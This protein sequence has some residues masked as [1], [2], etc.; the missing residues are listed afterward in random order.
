MDHFLPVEAP[1]RTALR[2]RSRTAWFLFSAS[3]AT[4]FGVAVALLVFWPLS[5]WRRFAGNICVGHTQVGLVLELGTVGAV[6]YVYNIDATGWRGGIFPIEDDERDEPSFGHL[7]IR[8]PN[9]H[10]DAVWCPIWALILLLLIPIAFWWK[11]HQKKR[12]ILL[13]GRCRRCGYDLRATPLR[14]PECGQ[15]A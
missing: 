8:Q 15:L 10:Y 2:G 4:A 11:S 12:A 5:H 3:A 13:A 9:L 14:C 1:D 6:R 7:H